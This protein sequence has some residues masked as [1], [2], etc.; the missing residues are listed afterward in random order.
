MLW[1]VQHISICISGF[2]YK[3]SLL[4]SVKRG[5]V[6]PRLIAM[7]AGLIIDLYMSTV[8]V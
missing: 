3:P 8:I 4:Y 6:D 5:L 2:F 1:N 7:H